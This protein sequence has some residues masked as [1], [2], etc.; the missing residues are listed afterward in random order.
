[1]FPLKMNLN[2]I[3]LI[4]AKYVFRRIIRNTHVHA[5]ILESGM[6][7][8][9][10]AKQTISHCSQGSLIEEQIS[11]SLVTPKILPQHHLS[12]L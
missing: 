1:M 2:I 11:F 5:D 7:S 6:T 8:I 3:T 9:Q 4:H 12:D 10:P